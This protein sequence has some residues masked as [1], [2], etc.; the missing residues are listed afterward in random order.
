MKL[1][2]QDISRQSKQIWGKSSRA[3]TEEEVNPT[4][5]GPKSQ[6]KQNKSYT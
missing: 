2:Y 1:N 6:Q 3:L 5:P 4:P